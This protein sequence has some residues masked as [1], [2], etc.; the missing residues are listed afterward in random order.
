VSAGSTAE[1]AEEEPGSGADAAGGSTT[2]T[3][4]NGRP[5]PGTQP[6]TSGE[7]TRVRRGVASWP[8]VR[9]PHFLTPALIFLAIRAVGIVVLALMAEAN[10]TT[11]TH[12]LTSWDGQWY[13]GIANGGYSDVSF[14]LVDA[15]GTRDANT[16]LAFF[17]GYPYLVRLLALLPGVSLVSAAILLSIISGVLG[18]YALLRIGER[19]GGSRRTGL[20]LVALFAAAPMAVVETMSYSEGMFCALAAWSLVGVLERRWLLAGLCAAAAGLAR[21]T[22]AALV[23]AVCLAAL[24]AIV[25]RRD[26][27]RPWLGGMVAPLGLLGYLG[28]VALRTGAL[29]GWFAL[30]ERGWDSHFDGGAATVRF[31]MKALTGSREMLQLTTIGLLLVAIVLLVVCFRTGMP[32][33]LL[34][35]GVAVLVMDV[36]SNGLMNSKSRLLLPAFTLLI[37][38]AVG[39]AKRRPCTAVGCVCGAVLFSS[40]FGAYALTVWPFAI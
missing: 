8:L 2:D 28:W 26:G 34:V 14:G 3:V 30:Q 9:T 5:K 27:W 16:A 29:N 11:L 24:V 23:L 20:L 25:A 4:T 38:V 19:V 18:S 7:G 39:L 10:N 15:H 37:P 21:P 12:S 36:G 22:A 40:W 31:T 1:V 13:L 33:P 6:V 32:W 17:P 35:Y